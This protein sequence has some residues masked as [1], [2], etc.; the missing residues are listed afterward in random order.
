[1]IRTGL[2]EP[3]IFIRSRVVPRLLRWVPDRVKYPS[4]LSVNHVPQHARDLRCSPYGR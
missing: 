2:P 1:M 3:K 4:V